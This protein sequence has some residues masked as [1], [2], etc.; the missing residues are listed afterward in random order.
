MV[1]AALFALAFAAPALA[2]TPA[3]WTT[4][5]APFR[6]ID[7][8]YYVGSEG[9]SAFLI[10]TPKGD[11]LIDGGLPSNAPMIEASIA[12]LGFRL[13]DVKILLNSHAHLDHAGG[14]ARLKADTGATLIASAGDKPLLEKGVYPGFEDRASL[15][16]PPVK[17][18][19]VIGDGQTVSLGGVTLTAHLTPGHTPGCTTWTFPVRE[20][21]VSH[22]AVVFCSVSVAANRLA[23]KPQ[24]PGIVADYQATFRKLPSIKADVFLAPH[25]EFFQLTRKR[26]AMGP[27]K[28]NPFIDPTGFQTFVKA[29]DVAF[30]AELAKQQGAAK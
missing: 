25:G 26:A 24:Y 9:L 14:L 21:G 23:P 10:V 12:R 11:I 15:R 13:A 22:Q 28:P 8:V 6:M 1:A 19:R 2:Q 3:A 5:Y 4:P 16:F 29:S 20:A 27:G 18:D 7:N 30:R 17:V